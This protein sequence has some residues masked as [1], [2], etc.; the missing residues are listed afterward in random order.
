M[1]K[2]ESSKKEKTYSRGGHGGGIVEGRIFQ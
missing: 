2:N 1:G